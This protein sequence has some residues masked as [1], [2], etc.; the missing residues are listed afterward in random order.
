[1]KASYATL[2]TRRKGICM[3]RERNQRYKLTF[4]INNVEK[5]VVSHP[6]KGYRIAVIVNVK[7]KPSLELLHK[8]VIHVDFNHNEAYPSPTDLAALP[9]G[10]VMKMQVYA[11]VK[12]YIKPQIP[13]L[14][15]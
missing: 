6:N 8:S 2:L 1:M 10:N 3:R 12:K 13:Y 11:E 4:K 9:G 7:S 14:I 15:P 5:D